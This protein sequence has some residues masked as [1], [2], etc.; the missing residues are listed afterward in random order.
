MEGILRI[1]NFKILSMEDIDLAQKIRGAKIS[2][3]Y[4]VRARLY[5]WQKFMRMETARDRR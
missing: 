5:A 4:F 1:S 3:F 2:A